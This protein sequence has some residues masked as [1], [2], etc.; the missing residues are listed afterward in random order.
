LVQGVHPAAE[1]P[2]ASRA[3]AQRIAAQAPLA[4]QSILASSRAAF[5]GDAKAEA[6]RLYTRAREL[7]KTED[8]QEGMRAF[9]ERR[10]GV[11]QGK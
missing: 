3:L 11:F 9:L 1:L 7:M 2:A 6:L 10:E 8:A 4:V 5:E